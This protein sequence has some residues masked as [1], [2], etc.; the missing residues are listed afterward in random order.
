[1]NSDQDQ[2]PP[3]TPGPLPVPAV[4]VSTGERIVS[5]DVLRGFAL[6]GILVMNIQMFAMIDAAY[7]IP[8]VAG[9]LTGINY[10]VW[11]LSHLL[12]DQKLMTIFSMLF[13]AGIL[14]MSQ[15]AE[16]TGRSAASVHY[17]RMGAL[18][19]IAL[20]HAYLLWLGDILYSYAMAGMIVFL[21]R[22]IRPVR[23]IALGVLAL[24]VPSILMVSFGS[25]MLSDESGA[26][27]VLQEFSADFVPNQEGI[28]AELAAYQGN[29]FGQIAFRFKDVV[30]FQT[31]VFVMWIFWRVSG[32]MLIGMALYK[33]GVFSAARSRMV[34]GYM[35]GVGLA[36]G[37]PAIAWEVKLNFAGDWEPARSFFLVGQ[38]NYW[39]SIIVSLAWVG[40]IMLICKSGVLKILTVPL[41]AVGRTALSNYLAHTIIC[42]TIFYGGYG[43]GLYGK[44]ERWEQILIVFAIW[45]F[46]LIA[47]P[48]WLRYFDFGPAEWLWRS[49]TY[50]RFQPMR[51]QRAEIGRSLTD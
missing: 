6:L 14:L 28:A 44:V 17:R 20:I 21:F 29:W 9:D 11:Y 47:S 51:R 26:A 37:L 12:T 19:I 5:I 15:R 7:M 13:G 1:M 16:A 25:F 35:L 27:K 39:A 30:Q 31:I 36:I 24:S 34:Y 33:L 8:T 38:I 18:L 43:F 49:M 46:Q 42:T 32:L 3:I 40:L 45:A 41:A 50:R 48:L 23:L 2:H 22:K 4:P 10:L